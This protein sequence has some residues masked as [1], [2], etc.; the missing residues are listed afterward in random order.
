MHG[1]NYLSG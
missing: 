1:R